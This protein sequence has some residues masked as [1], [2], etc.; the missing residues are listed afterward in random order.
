MNFD[1]SKAVE[2]LQL[3]LDIKE[4]SPL[5]ENV[6][7]LLS[8]AFGGLHTLNIRQLAR[9]DW[10]D[11]YHITHNLSFKSLS[12]VDNDTL[13]RLLVE[14]FDRQL[15]VELSARAP[16]CLELM[17]H[18]RDVN[19]ERWSKSIPSLEGAIDRA[20]LFMGG[21]TGPSLAELVQ[22]DTV[23]GELDQ[24]AADLLADIGTPF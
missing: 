1:N 23:R 22:A 18:Q 20:R 6:A 21:Y 4:F 11:D 14:S 17:F 5:G 13:T 8:R 7:G 16:K 19:H 2:W 24:A 15:R 12:N 3:A 10:A 9:T